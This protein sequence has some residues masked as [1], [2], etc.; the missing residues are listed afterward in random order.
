MIT[1]IITK[2]DVSFLQKSHLR[3]SVREFESR[4]PWGFKPPLFLRKIRFF[5][6]NYHFFAKISIYKKKFYMIRRAIK[7]FV[8]S[9]RSIF[10]YNKSIPNRSN[11]GTFSAYSL[12]SQNSMKFPVSY[13]VNYILS[14]FKI[15]NYSVA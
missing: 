10:N 4:K 13:R 5:E 14:I 7:F 1:F 11:G 15:L 3:A 8:F 2:I 12:S 9:Y 6:I